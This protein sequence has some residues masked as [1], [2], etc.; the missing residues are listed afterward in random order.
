MIKAVVIDDEH[1][2]I[3]VIK[4]YLKEVND[5]SFIS[6]FTNP[7]EGLN[8]IS[9]N[10]CPLVFLDINMPKLDGMSLARLLPDST[11][12]IFTTAYANF[13]ADAFDIDAIDYLVK[14]ISLERFIKATEKAKY[15]IWRSNNNHIQADYITLKEGKR[16]YRV[17]VNDIYYCKAFGDY[18]RVFTTEKT[19]ITKDRFQSFIL[20]L[21]SNFCRIHRSYSINLI[22]LEYLEGNHVLIQDKKLPISESFRS[23][24]V[25]KLKNW[26]K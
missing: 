14:P 24:I 9:K 15:R 25:K 6:G 22:H 10:Q 5:I 23:E 2:A 17:D 21:P 11:Q 16:L 8:Y 18:V 13:A 26:E 4:G 7:M 12:V 1:L 3:K 20:G 19:Y